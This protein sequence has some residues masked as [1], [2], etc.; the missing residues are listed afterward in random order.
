MFT[1]GGGG[2]NIR[3][4]AP[5]APKHIL[6]SDSEE[7][8]SSIQPSS[9]I[10]PVNEE[11]EKDEDIVQVLT[12]SGSV[13]NFPSTSSNLVTPAPQP[14]PV[15]YRPLPTISVTKP[16][17]TPDQNI[18]P[19]QYRPHKAKPN[20][21]IDDIPEGRSVYDHTA[22]NFRSKPTKQQKLT[23]DIP[24]SR[25]SYDQGSIQY[26]TKTSK[27]HKL[28]EDIPESR[29]EFDSI[30]L[31]YRS[32]PLKQQ[33]YIDDIPEARSYQKQRQPPKKLTAETDYY[34]SRPKKPVAQVNLEK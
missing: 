25:S 6:N 23:E 7:N 3:P 5:P 29:P 9:E 1:S 19:V 32:K 26:R 16:T 18:P 33:K 34:T 27:P 4:H 14:I 24:E 15:Q 31:Q 11:N 20:K 10:K 13:P 21:P 2:R 22:I 12:H 28:N 30:S 17:L 8:S